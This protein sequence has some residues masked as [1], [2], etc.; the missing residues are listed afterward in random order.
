MR[1]FGILSVP[2]LPGVGK[3][4]KVVDAIF[5]TANSAIQSSS[6]KDKTARE[7][8]NK[9]TDFS[10]IPVEK[11]LGATGVDRQMSVVFFQINKFDLL[12]HKQFKL[13][14]QNIALIALSANSALR[15]RGQSNPLSLEAL[16]NQMGYVEIEAQ[17]PQ[18]SPGP[19]NRRPAPIG[20]G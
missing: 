11:R 5:Q 18:N 10:D 7:V 9:V 1:R 19:S 3:S 6:A 20:A 16:K 12:T 17:A 4:R 2:S 14:T 13:A 8:K 15:S